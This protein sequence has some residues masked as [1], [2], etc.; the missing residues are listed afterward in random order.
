MPFCAKRGDPDVLN[1]GYD[2]RCHGLAV[3]QAVKYK[4]AKSGGGTWRG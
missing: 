3:H 4:N 1:S 2:Y